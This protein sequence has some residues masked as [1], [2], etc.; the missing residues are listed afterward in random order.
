MYLMYVDESGD[1]GPVHS[2]PTRYFI[3]SAIVIHEMRWRNIL[4]ELVQFRQMLKATKGLKISEEI[5]CT[6]FI[7]RPG[8]LVR[9]P[10]NDRLD[11]IKKCIDWLDSQTDISVYSVVVDKNEKPI[12]YD[13]F[14]QAWNALLM[15]FE[16]TINHRNFPGPRN[17]TDMGM[18][19]SD[20]T[21]GNKLRTLLRKMRHYNMIPSLFGGARNMKLQYIIEDPVL[22]DSQYSFLHQMNDVVAYCAKQLYEPNSYMKRKG[23]N[24]FYTRL[25]HV[26]L[27]AVCR[28]N[29]YGIVEL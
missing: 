10:R 23:A 2:S 11:I 18:V 6:N 4:Q 14:T 8:P 26:A 21:D 5:H 7:S 22:R 15:R 3:L 16:N 12:G 9:I 27:K 25:D 24:T 28:K 13:V 1:I 29:P 20:N 19:L 17:I